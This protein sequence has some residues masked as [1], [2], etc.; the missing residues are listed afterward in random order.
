MRVLILTNNDVGLYKF[1][2]E[3]I[4]ELIHPGRYIAGRKGK[5]YK[6]Y[7][8]LPDGEFV[9]KFT[10]L[11]CEYINTPIDRR[12]VNP[13]KDFGLLTLYR[14]L[15]ERIKPDIVLGYT[16]KPNIYGGM[17]CA[18]KDIPYICN[19]TGLGTAVENK[20]ILQIIG[21]RQIFLRIS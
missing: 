16:I 7:V 17:A 2:K 4:E 1:R 18:E 19:I 9:H 12:G 20:G 5:P 11:G 3:L 21:K 10:E 8:S 6:V 13:L 15:L 14:K